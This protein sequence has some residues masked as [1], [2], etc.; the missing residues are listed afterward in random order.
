V[1]TKTKPKAKAKRPQTTVPRRHHL[2]RR[3]HQ[4]LATDNNGSDDE[5]L[6]TQ[7][8]AWWFSEQWLEIGRSHGYGP[9][10]VMLGP[11]TIRYRRGACRKY[12]A[13]R[14]YTH[15]AEYR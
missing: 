14:V 12:L 1:P 8:V 6:T 4:I 9:P 15:T 13:E 5:M 3:V 7:Q 11:K 10:F 2:D